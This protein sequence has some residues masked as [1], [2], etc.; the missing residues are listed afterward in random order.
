MPLTVVSRCRDCRYFAI[1]KLQKVAS[2]D[3]V[4]LC[5]RRAPRA[6]VTHDINRGS[7]SMAWWPQVSADHDW[8]GE[9]ECDKE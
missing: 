1:D 8:C 3:E 7:D 4:G 5:R 2:D 6:R 9:G